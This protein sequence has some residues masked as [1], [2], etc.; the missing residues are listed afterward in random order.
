MFAY[1]RLV[2]GLSVSHAFLAVAYLIGSNVTWTKAHGGDEVSAP[3]AMA[4]IVCAC[5]LGFAALGTGAFVLGSV[6]AFDLPGATIAAIV[7]FGVGCAARRR[8]PFGAAYWRERGRAVSEAFDGGNVVVYLAMLAAAFPAINVANSGTDA[9]SYHW[10]Y[11]EDFL[12]AGR[13]VVD[14]FLRQAFYTHNDLMLVAMV[15]MTG[16]RA[17]LEFVPWTFA[18]LSA[19]GIASGV[20]LAL[21]RATASVVTGCA[22]AFSVVFSPAYLR[23]TDSGYLDVVLGFFAL[24]SMLAVVR[25]FD[26]RDGDWRWLAASA[27]LGAFLI[28]SKNSLL[29]LVAVYAVLLAIAC[30]RL[31]CTG[32]QTGTVLAILVVLAAPWYVRNL[33]LSGD[34]IPPVLNLV[35]HGH[36]GLVTSAEAGY[37]AKDL[38]R[39]LVP[40]QWPLVPFMAY[41]HTDSK[42]FVDYGSSA[43]MLLLYA[44]TIA[45]F[46]F[47]VVFRKRLSPGVV[48]PVAFLTVLI[49]YWLATS[50]FMRYALIFYPLLALCCGL[51]VGAIWPRGSRRGWIVAAGAVLC[52]AYT[53]SA[54][55]AKYMSDYLANGVLNPPA[56]YRD[57]ETFLRLDVAGYTEEEFVSAKLHDLGIR[58][59]LYQ[60]APPLNYYYRRDGIESIGDWIGPAGFFRFYRAVDAGLG[61]QFLTSLGVDAVLVDPRLVIGGLAVPIGHQLGDAGYCL[62]P[63]PQSVML[64]YVRQAACAS[65]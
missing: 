16:A 7:L 15:M 50:T 62:V 49:A 27:A 52:V 6:G 33:A 12:R 43:L 25:A 56:Y 61:A 31:R 34:I 44:P 57:D 23:W 10:A 13:F 32:R 45:V 53:P 2:E 9:L 17:F 19:L 64:L 21:P 36:D 41:F 22:L 24:A 60:L 35:L 29:P 40:A 54:L 28:G 42:Y 3:L 37:V 39:G 5:A 51:I 47:I 18:L 1:V 20:R 58:G 65:R 8:N 4:R 48:I 30:R 14:P 55:D 38:S 46:L 59:R 63:V 11:A 26:D